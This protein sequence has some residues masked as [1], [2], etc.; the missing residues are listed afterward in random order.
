MLYG[1]YIWGVYPLKKGNASVPRLIGLVSAVSAQA[2]F[3]TLSVF[4]QPLM[5]AARGVVTSYLSSAIAK[6]ADT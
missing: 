2:R 6:A 4:S 3:Q 5:T 1:L